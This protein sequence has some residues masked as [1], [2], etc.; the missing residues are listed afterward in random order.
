MSYRLVTHS[1]CNGWNGS[2]DISIVSI[3]WCIFWMRSLVG[4][5]WPGFHF[6]FT[7]FSPKPIG[8]TF[9]FKRSLLHIASVC[10]LI[11]G[12]FFIL[13]ENSYKKFLLVVFLTIVHWQLLIFYL[14]HSATNCSLKVYL[15]VWILSWFYVIY[16]KT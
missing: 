8:F 14:F 3:K 7:T 4:H 16:F 15:F 6:V 5:T 13:M 10:D 2:V 1:N 12:R 9:I 11:A